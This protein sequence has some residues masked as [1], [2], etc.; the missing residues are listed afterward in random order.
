[1]AAPAAPPKNDTAPYDNLGECLVDPC[2]RER[3]GTGN[4]RTLIDR[5]RAA[6]IVTF[7]DLDPSEVNQQV[8]V[9][10]NDILT[11]LARLAQDPRHAWSTMRWTLPPRR[12]GF[13]LSP[14]SSRAPAPPP[15]RPDPDPRRCHTLRAAAHPPRPPFP[16][17]RT[18]PVTSPCDTCRMREPACH[19]NL[20]LDNRSTG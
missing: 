4:A 3:S 1:M 9:L 20:E 7:A 12:Q 18:T 10:R 8:V 15:L 16:R 13:R 5:A 6:Q 19:E 14:H 2:L 11:A 17:P